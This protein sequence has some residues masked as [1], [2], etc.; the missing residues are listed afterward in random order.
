MNRLARGIYTSACRALLGPTLRHEW[1]HPRYAEPNERP[2][3]LAFASKWLARL[4][5]R[6]VLDVGAGGSAWPFV[7]AHCGF[8]VTA[9][10]PGGRYWGGRL[11]NRHYHVVQDDITRS[12]LSER[13][14]AVTCISVLEHIPDHRAAFSGML[15]RLEEGGHLLLTVPYNERRFVEDV[16]STRPGAR[17]GKRRSICRVYSRAQLDE[18][19]RGNPGR[20]IEQEYYQVFTGEL[21]AFG[22]RIPLPKRVSVSE[23]HHLTC[24]AIQK[25][26][27]GG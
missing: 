9:I 24:L 21:W 2:V 17:S 3:E 8:R 20:I 27:A 23:P 13:F 22:E 14:D 19:L 7:L 6:R 12:R 1:K 5:P 16:Y 11:F 15:E 10:D 25:T 18:W 4:Y 26:A